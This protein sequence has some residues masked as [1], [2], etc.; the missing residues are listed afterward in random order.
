MEKRQEF[1]SVARENGYAEAGESKDGSTVWLRKAT[2]DVGTDVHKRLCIDSITDSATVFWQTVP[3]KLNSKTFRTV[4][5]LKDW[6][7]SEV[8]LCSKTGADQP[9]LVPNQSPDYR[10]IPTN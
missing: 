8:G 10:R 5:D 4:S 2:P 9:L 3:A 6:F 1:Q 7:G